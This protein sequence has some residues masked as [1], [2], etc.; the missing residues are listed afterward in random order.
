MKT[1]FWSHQVIINHIIVNIEIGQVLSLY[2]E[3]E[4]LSKTS[5]SSMR[6]VFGQLAGTDGG[7]FV[8]VDIN[9]S[10]VFQIKNADKNFKANPFMMF[11]RVPL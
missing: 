7:M 4:T 1:N 6:Q 2:K 10:E 8:G 11:D 9:T 5:Q 3:S